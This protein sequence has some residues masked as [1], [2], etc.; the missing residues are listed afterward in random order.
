MHKWQRPFV[1]RIN[2]II[3]VAGFWESLVSVCDYVSYIY[4]YTSYRE[5]DDEQVDLVFQRDLFSQYPHMIKSPLYRSFFW[6]QPFSPKMSG[7]VPPNKMPKRY[8]PVI[9]YGVLENVPF[10]TDFPINTSI[11]TDF[12]GDETRGLTWWGHSMIKTWDFNPGLKPCGQAFG[13]GIQL[14]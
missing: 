14:Q 3:T 12:P 2:I 1:R 11:H 4:I 6:Y 13:A 8:P 7:K 9:K 5:I 10:I